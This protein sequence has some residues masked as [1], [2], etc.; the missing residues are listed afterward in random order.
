FV[1]Q[2]ILRPYADA[3]KQFL[4]LLIHLGAVSGHPSM[5]SLPSPSSFLPAGAAHFLR[6]TETKGEETGKEIF[7]GAS[8]RNFYATLL[9]YLLKRYAV[10]EKIFEAAQGVRFPFLLDLRGKK[11]KAEGA[12]S[13]VES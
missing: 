11:R 5:S 2:N 6:A 1:A 7:S 8:S 9:E 3:A 13:D 10:E 12:D 4:L